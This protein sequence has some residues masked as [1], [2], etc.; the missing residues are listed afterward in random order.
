MV[1]LMSVIFFTSTCILV[2]F[3]ML[4]PHPSKFTDASAVKHSIVMYAYAVL[5]EY[6]NSS[7]SIDTSMPYI[8]V[9]ASDENG[10]LHVFFDY[11]KVFVTFYNNG[12][13][14]GCQSGSYDKYV[15]NRLF[16]DI[17]DAVLN[18]INDKRFGG[19]L[20]S[21]EVNNITM[22]FTFLYNKQLINNSDDDFMEGIELGIHGL[23]ISKGDNKAYFKETVPIMKNYDVEETLERLCEKAGL[24]NTCF[25]E[26]D[27]KVYRYDAITFLGERDG[28]VVDLYRGNPLI[29]E[30]DIT[31]DFIRERILLGGE[32]FLANINEYSGLLEYEYYPSRNA[33]SPY[34]NH[35]RQL[36]AAWVL[37]KLMDFTGDNRFVPLIERIIDYYLSYKVDETGFSYIKIRRASNIAYNAFLVLALSEYKDYPDREKLIEDLTK[38]IIHQQNDDGSY[39]PIFNSKKVQGV[40]YYPGEAMLSL[41]VAFRENQNMSYLSSVEK[42]FS[43]Y[44]EYWRNNKNTAFIPWHTQVYLLLYEE[45]GN[46]EYADFVF[47]MNDWLI[48]NYQIRENEGYLDEVGGF[49][50]GTPTFSSSVYLEGI[51]D[52][53]RLAMIVNDDYHIEKY[54][55]SIM[56]GTRF[57]LQT[58]FTVQ[59][60]FYLRDQ[61]KAIGGFRKSLVDNTIRVDA[62][63]HALNALMKVYCNGL[64]S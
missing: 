25:Y 52:A 41:M 21:N 51:N 35:V 43:Y 2:G 8:N 5:D 22:T 17:K 11:D 61:S 10:S 36:A 12:M 24:K 15:E 58:Q 55:R 1:L 48:D 4:C 32:W 44:Q 54:R 37:T 40:N 29:R 46:Q 62:V 16:L 31:Q 53:Y 39:D 33:Y 20:K 64:F 30:E 63:Q 23:E 7:S 19:V 26:E 57:I 50:H 60:T 47:E 9:A 45:T 28:T 56:L 42:A 27:T 18:T 38:G 6:F 3:F 13:I 59:N 14:R 34:N 49:P